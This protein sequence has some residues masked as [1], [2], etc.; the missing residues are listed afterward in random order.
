M[1]ISIRGASP[2]SALCTL[3]AVILALICS[4]PLHAQTY[5]GGITGTV[6]DKTGAAIANANVSAVETATNTPYQAVSSSAGQF[7]FTNL[8][9]GSYTVTISFTGFA[10]AKYDNVQVAAGTSYVLPAKLL[11]SSSTTTV[12]VRAATMTLDTVTDMQ[13]TILPETVVQNLP[14]SGRDFT[15]MISQTTGF[16]GLSTNGGGGYASVNG[17]RTNAVNWQIEGTDNNDLWWNIPAVNQG[18]VSAIAGVIFPIDAIENFSFVTTG[19]TALG[20]NPGGTANL[21]IKSGTNQLHGTAYYF[22]HNE[23][24]ERQNPFSTTKPASRNQHYGFSIGGPILKSKL[25]FFGA[26]EHQNFLIGALN[27]ATEPSAAYQT[28]AYSVLN[29]Y[30]VP[31]STVAANLLNGNGTLKGLW[32][33]SALTGPAQPEHRRQRSS[34]C[35]VVRRP[36]HPDCANLL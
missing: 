32:P 14:N 20:R 36:G 2:K 30:G 29:F 24:F 11:I 1:Y 7:N 33:A 8:P 22:N 5:R 16:A 3:A 10:T 21:I 4:L 28:A 35:Q 31:H 25:F 18:G 26:G 6:N 9:V 23:F 34:F 19:E 15:Q 17:T 12:E 13:A 27:H